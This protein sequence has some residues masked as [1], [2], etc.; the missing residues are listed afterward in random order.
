MGLALIL[1]ARSQISL[2]K[3]FRYSF[4]P[5]RRLLAALLLLSVFCQVF[6]S[7]QGAPRAH[8]SEEQARDVL[9]HWQGVPHHHDAQRATH[10]DNTDESIQHLLADAGPGAAV[11][12]DLRVMPLV[13]ERSPPP[14]VA[15]DS[16]EPSPFLDGPRRPPRLT[17]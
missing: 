2:I 10:Q 16:V 3:A 5:M 17:A 15:A 7:E 11:L 13:P 12:V 8:G 1:C 4:H 6:A 9:L 14:V